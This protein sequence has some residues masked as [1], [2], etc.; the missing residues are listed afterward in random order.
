MKY[1]CDSYLFNYFM[2]INIEIVTKQY[3][4]RKVKDKKRLI[5]NTSDLNH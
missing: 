5:C 3:L 2:L 4:L 1:L